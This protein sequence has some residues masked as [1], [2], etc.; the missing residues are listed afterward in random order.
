MVG[1]HAGLVDDMKMMMQV[2]KKEQERKM[3]K[4]KKQRSVDDEHAMIGQQFGGK[5][6]CVQGK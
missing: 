1:D 6:M 2:V 5:S 3:W 4:E